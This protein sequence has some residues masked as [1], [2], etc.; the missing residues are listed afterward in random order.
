ME[1]P[2][3]EQ[4]PYPD[5]A[6]KDGEF[7]A[8]LKQIEAKTG[9]DVLA[10]YA[11][12]MGRQPVWKAAKLRVDWDEGQFTLGRAATLR[13]NIKPIMEFGVAEIG[14]FEIIQVPDDYLT[15]FA[16]LAQMSLAVS[17]TFGIIEQIPDVPGYM[18]WA[19]AG[20]VCT[21]YLIAVAASRRI[22]T[23]AIRLNLSSPSSEHTWVE[24]RKRDFS[25]STHSKETRKLG[26]R[27]AET[28]EKSGF[29]GGIPPDLTYDRIWQV[30]RIPAYVR[31]GLVLILLV[32]K[33]GVEMI[34]P[35]VQTVSYWIERLF[36]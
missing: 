25:L 32:I 4:L 27:I 14:S 2:G 35:V 23:P 28:L 26:E 17:L 3:K 13:R 11:H 21:I 15:P 7:E 22:L 29:R 12:P 5:K 20:I 9:I 8:R 31:S 1:L 34:P 36:P 18:G 33:L 6:Q 10:R 24:F 19:V 16:H 30:N